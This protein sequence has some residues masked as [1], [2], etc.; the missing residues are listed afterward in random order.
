[1]L[2]TQKLQEK[3]Q[4]EVTIQIAARGFNIIFRGKNIDPA[5]QVNPFIDFM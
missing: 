5:S 2:Q 3:D 1:M 4:V